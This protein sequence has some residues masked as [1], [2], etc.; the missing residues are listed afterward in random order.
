VATRGGSTLSASGSPIRHLAGLD[1]DAAAGAATSL[2]EVVDAIVESALDGTLTTRRLEAAAGRAFS[3]P[4]VL[5]P[6]LRLAL[7]RFALADR[8]LLELPPPDALAAGLNVLVAVGQVRDGSLWIRSAFGGAACAARVGP[9]PTRRIKTIAQ[10]ALATERAVGLERP[11]AIAGFPVLRHGAVAGALVVRLPSTDRAPAAAAASAGADALSTVLERAATLEANAERDRR[12]TESANRKLARL[13][14]DMHDGPLQ[15]VIALLG[16]V[17]LYK[18]QLKQHLVGLPSA[19]LLLGRVDD[20]EARLLAI[21]DELRQF[22]Q[23]FESPSMLELPFAEAVQAEIEPTRNAGVEVTVEID[24]DAELVTASQRIALLRIAQ[25]GLS[26]V[27]D[28]SGA[29]S[30]SLSVLDHGT[31]VTL[32]LTDDGAGF[33]VERTL[34]R[35]ARR[36]RLGLVGMAERVRLLGGTFDLESSPGAGTTI[37]VTLPRWKPLDEGSG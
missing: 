17:R 3:S 10:A 32:R 23:S 13:T 24:L 33:N 25:E 19:D 26:N 36:G 1:R 6:E 34:V 27:R 11:G 2:G 31:H 8:R 15:D 29:A 4:A 22:A 30:V 21:D 18:S 14:L 28:H 5:G 20:F 9:E 35:A 7:C 37:A 12:L 16:D